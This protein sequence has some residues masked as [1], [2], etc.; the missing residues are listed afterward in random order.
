MGAKHS[1]AIRRHDCRPVRLVMRSRS[2]LFVLMM[3]SLFGWSQE[4][5]QQRVPATLT[6][7]IPDVV[8]GEVNRGNRLSAGF[9]ISTVYDD[10]VLSSRS[11]HVNDWQYSFAP[12]IRLEETKK[13][14]RWSL[15]YQ[16]GVSGYRDL[17]V[18]TQSTHALSG[19][20][21]FTLSPRVQLRIRQDY[22]RSSDP[23]TIV[24]SPVPELGVVNSPNQTI[25]TSSAIRTLLTSVAEIEYALSPHS[26]IGVSGTFAKS[27]Y[28]N[29]LDT[30]SSLVPSAGQTVN[31]SAY[32]SLKLSPRSSVG[33]QYVFE[34]ISYANTSGRVQAHSFLV[35]HTMNLSAHS[36]VMLYAGPE[37]TRSHNLTLGGGALSVP[38]PDDSSWTPSLGAMYSWIGSRTDFGVSAMRRVSDGGGILNAATLTSG[39]F[40]AGRRF[41]RSWSARSELMLARNESAGLSTLDGTLKSLIATAEIE[42]RLVNNLRLSVGYNRIYQ[43]G[44]RA[45]QEIGNHNR[46]QLSLQYSLTRP[47]GK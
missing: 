37:N 34:N 17:S 20:L 38:M 21:A 40:S 35:F 44:T 14:V 7:D 15:Q 27:D 45:Y 30:A 3:F 43:N 47:L 18:G 23:F 4:P 42:R 25:V 13:R 29:L 36:S 9:S 10:N 33:L 8:A 11:E 32:Y 41:T 22:T 26:S 31:G 46:I 6:A 24:Q 12:N 5:E 16:A 28:S 39:T 19:S 1:T 2:V